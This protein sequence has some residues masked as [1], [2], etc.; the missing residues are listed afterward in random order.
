[1]I[2]DSGVRPYVRGQHF[3]AI[4][5]LFES[6]VHHIW[7]LTDT[8]SCKILLKSFCRVEELAL[9]NIYTCLVWSD[10]SHVCLYGIDNVDTIAIISVFFEFYQL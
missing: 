4:I 2:F 7:T 1:M 10:R 3:G 9:L 8:L 5:S 6:H